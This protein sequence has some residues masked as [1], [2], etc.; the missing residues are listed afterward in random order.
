M[1][2]KMELAVP[3]IEAARRAGVGRSSIYEA[4]NRGDLKLRKNGRR[5]LIL[6]DDLRAWVLALPEATRFKTA[7]KGKLQNDELKNL[8]GL[9]QP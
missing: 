4:V 9:I 5:S 8:P 3:I 2:I 7:A 6:V 1:E